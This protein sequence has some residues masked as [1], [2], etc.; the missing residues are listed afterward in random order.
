[1]SPDLFLIPDRR[2]LSPDPESKGGE[3]GKMEREEVEKF[4]NKAFNFA[5][6]KLDPRR[7]EKRIKI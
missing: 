3:S 2:I 5:D 1:M 4:I 7:V 6:Y